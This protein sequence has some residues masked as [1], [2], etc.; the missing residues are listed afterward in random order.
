MKLAEF[1]IYTIMF[2]TNTIFKI[3][4]KQA[5]NYF[6]KCSNN[7]LI[8]LLVIN[9]KIKFTTHILKS[10]IIYHYQINKLDYLNISDI[11][12]IN[13]YVISLQ[14]EIIFCSSEL[15]KIDINIDKN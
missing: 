12:Y 10:L 3:C 11:D 9:K 1:S 8:M 13:K 6:T 5:I 15:T 14:K 4:C 2:L 7:N